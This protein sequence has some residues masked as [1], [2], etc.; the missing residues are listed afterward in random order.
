MFARV[1]N[2]LG[3]RWFLPELS[4]TASHSIRPAEGMVF[5]A[6]PCLEGARKLMR[7]ATRCVHHPAIS[8]DGYA[9]LAVPTHR[10]STIVYP[11][12]T[13]FANRKDRGFDGYTYGLH[14]TPTTRTLEAQLT[15]LHGGQRTMLVP[16]GQAA[17]TL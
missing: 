3:D 17:V 14:G 13:S 5:F 9:S 2:V 7:D 8:E 16:S 1:A 10:A 11:D 15:A 12:A 6:R 4:N